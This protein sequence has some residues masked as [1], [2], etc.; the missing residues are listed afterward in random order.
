M[1]PAFAEHGCAREKRLSSEM[2]AGETLVSVV[3]PLFNEADNLPELYHRLATSLER[4]GEQFELVF[5][6][7]GSKD[8]TP[9]ILEDLFRRDDRIVAVHLS[10][11]FGHQAAMSAGI[12]QARGQAVILMDGDLQDPPEMLGRFLATWR[13]GFEVV[14]AVRTKRKEG[15]WKRFA[16]ALFY[17]T[18]RVLCDLDIPLDSGDFCLMDRAVVDTLKNMPERSRFLR[19]L[20]C[21]AGYRQTGI[22]YE[23]AARNAG[24]PKYTFRALLRLALDG[25]VGFSGVPLALVSY[26][27]LA[28]L[29]LALLVGGWLSYDCLRHAQAPAGWSLTL[30]AVLMIGALHLL[31]LGIIGQYLQRIFLETKRRPTYV[32]GSLRRKELPAIKRSRAPAA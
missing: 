24:Q 1:K 17:R 16:Y 20:R 21:F 5:I 31:S 30:L 26:L 13:E 12:D 32:I 7:D 27:G 15:F 23:R 3:V 9:R 19:G 28:T 4:E 11:N 25:L 10:R 8:V 29:G 6:D 22:P 18:L 2:P 14:Y